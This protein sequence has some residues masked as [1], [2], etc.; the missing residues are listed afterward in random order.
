MVAPLLS[1]DGSPEGSEDGAQSF[2]IICGMCKS[3]SMG[4][5]K[6]YRS[7]LEWEWAGNKRML[8]FW[9]FLLLKA[10]WEDKQWRDQTI[11]RGSFITTIDSLSKECG[12]PEKTV[13]RYLETLIVAKQVT[14][15]TTN[16][17]TIITICNYDSYQANDQTD[18][19]TNDQTNDQQLK[20]I[21]NKEIY[22]ERDNKSAGA[23]VHTCAY[24]L[25]GEPNPL[26]PSQ[27][28]YVLSSVERASCNFSPDAEIQLKRRKLRSMLDGIADNPDIDMPVDERESFVDWFC[29]PI[30]EGS[31]KVRAENLPAF[32]VYSTAK[33]WM[34]KRRQQGS[35]QTP[36]EKQSLSD[37]YKDLMKD[38]RQR[39]G[40]YQ[41]PDSGV[42][43]E[44]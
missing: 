37:Y 23:H 30:Y 6:L 10:N 29:E 15:Q 12:L 24:A 19:Q 5:I 31:N 41:Q 44:Q 27:P 14:K 42:P 16:Q 28:F 22:I 26:P 39:Y 25:E 13:R 38:I 36:K 17:N 21:R 40:T 43:D 3:K 20:N 7:I 8:L 1:A 35:R 4:Y 34:D 18:D 33:R 32:T 11:K 2:Y 9:I